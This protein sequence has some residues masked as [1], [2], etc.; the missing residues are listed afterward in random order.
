ML[1]IIGTLGI[2]LFPA[3]NGPYCVTH[4]PVTAFRAVRIGLMLMLSLCCP[5]QPRSESLVARLSSYLSFQLEAL[6]R[7]LTK[8]EARVRRYCKPRPFFAAS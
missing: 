7:Q 5:R 4:G 2:L 6:T 3:A 8:R 1:A